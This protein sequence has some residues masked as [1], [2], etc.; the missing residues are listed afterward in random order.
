LA[1]I[2]LAWRIALFLVP[3]FPVSDLALAAAVGRVPATTAG[4]EVWSGHAALRSREGF[5]AHGAHPQLLC[6]RRVKHVAARQGS[7]RG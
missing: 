3:S 5:A 2:I 4:L 7:R 6:A 1:S